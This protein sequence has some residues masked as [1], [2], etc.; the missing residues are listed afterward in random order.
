[1]IGIVSAAA[2][3][4]LDCGITFILQLI[5]QHYRGHHSWVLRKI[6][7]YNDCRYLV[8]LLFR[9]VVSRRMLSHSVR[10]SFYLLIIV[11]G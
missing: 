10:L 2:L 4:V 3:N 8:K 11:G 6:L 5:L 1:M 9:L 7:S